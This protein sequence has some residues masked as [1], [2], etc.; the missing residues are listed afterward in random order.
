MLERSIMDNMPE[1]DDIERFNYETGRESEY[2]FTVSAF[3]DLSIEYGLDRVLK[4]VLHLR[5]YKIKGV[6]DE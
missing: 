1:D 4:E 5:Q 6:S 2:W 3:V